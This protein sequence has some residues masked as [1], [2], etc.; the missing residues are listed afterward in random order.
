MTTNHHLTTSTSTDGLREATSGPVLAPTDPGYDDVRRVW[1]ASI[2][3]RPALIVQ[4]SGVADVIAAVLFAAERDL[5]I[6][7]RGGGHS[8]A[9]LGTCDDGLLVDLE[10]M[11]GIRVNAGAREV[12]AQGG[13]TWGELDHETAAF[14]LATTGGMVSTTGIA[15]LTLGGGVGWLMRKYGLSCDNLIGADIVTA[16]AQLRHASEDEHADLFWALRGG[17]GNFGIVT[18]LE[19]RLHPVGTVLGGA[20]FY[21]AVNAA[22]VL[23]FYAASAPTERDELVT[24]LEFTTAPD[25]DD[26]PAE[27]RGKPVIALAL[28]YCGPI[29]DG[30]AAIEPWRR[31]AP[32][33]ADFVGPMPYSELQMFFDEDYPRGMWSY[34]KSHYVDDLSAEAISALAAAGDARPTKRS[35]IDIHHLEGAPARVEPDSSAFDERRVRY[36]V[37]FGGVCADEPEMKRCR[38]WAKKHWSALASYGTG[39][40]YV[41]FMSDTDAAAV[42]AAWGTAKYERLVAVK[43]QHDPGNRFRFN[44]N[45]APNP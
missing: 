9:G 30:E 11:K 19:Y 23:A 34:V 35:F 39:L 29:A 6:A 16:D 40:T 15:G 5:P 27:Y 36:L 33:V 1:N 2:D 26:F 4:P 3:R 20:L 22:D 43:N 44:H 7:V 25:T 31:V 18:S 21:P 41:N 38:D 28:C 42:Q 37:M 12:V 14:G 45:I 32:L 10:L 24:L 8:F 13:V 17:G